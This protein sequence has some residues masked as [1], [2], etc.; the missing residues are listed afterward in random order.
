MLKSLVKGGLLGGLTIFLWGAVSWT[1]L[2]WH[3]MATNV[4]SNEDMVA[5]AIMANAPKP[6]V[7]FM[8]SVRN[9]PGATSEQRK[10]MMAAAEQRMEKGPAVFA[11]IRLAGTASMAPFLLTG[12]VISILGATFGTY[13]LLKTQGL[14]YFGRVGFMTMFALTAGVVCFLP[15]W[16]WFGFSAAYTLVSIL[17]LVI[18][19]FLAGLV[20][21][22]V[23]SPE[24]T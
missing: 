12:I 6:G 20:I 16:N 18:G 9:E 3:D 22:K 24:R 13:L 21:A 23:A 17:D 14:S 4:F 15:F 8:P 1:V 10:A 5:Q 2:S 19:W 7:Y 11:A